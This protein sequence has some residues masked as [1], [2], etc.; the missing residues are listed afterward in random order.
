M[1]EN[2][3]RNIIIFGSAWFLNMNGPKKACFFGKFILHITY[4][5]KRKTVLMVIS[6]PRFPGNKKKEERL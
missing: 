2:I 3:Y 1:G 5:S 4:Y 6:T